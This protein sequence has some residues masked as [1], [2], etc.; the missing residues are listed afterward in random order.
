MAENQVYADNDGNLD[1][2]RGAMTTRADWQLA[3]LLSR[4]E[5]QVSRRL[6]ATLQREDLS[7]DQ[8][9]VLSLLSDGTGHTMSD[10]GDHVMLP[11]ATLTRVIDRLVELAL[12]YRRPDL[13]D[14]RRV[15]VFLST[16]GHS[17]H[18]R[19]A[20]IIDHEEAAVMAALG[21]EERDLLADFLHRLAT[22]E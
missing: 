16:R 20:D 17:L 22:L 6:S 1:I 11:A 10:V 12:I 5:H 7:L 21:D 14:R 3:D 15:H 13:E 19:L 4:A 18:N 8:W 9:R 2:T